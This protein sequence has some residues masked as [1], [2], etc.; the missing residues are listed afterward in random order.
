MPEMIGVTATISGISP[1]DYVRSGQIIADC[2]LEALRKIR[3]DAVFAIADLCVEAEALGCSLFYPEDN[4]PYVKKVILHN[5]GA[6]KKIGIPDP[7][8]DGR[9]PEILKA[10]RIL[11]QEVGGSV[12]VFAHVIGPITLAARIMDVEKMLYLIVDN[13]DKF[14]DVLNFCQQVSTTFAM[15]LVEE[16]A[17]G[18]IMFDS[19]ASPSVLPPKI[20]RE[21]E[22]NPVRTVFAKVKEIDPEVMTWYSVA[23]PV[24]TNKA[25]LKDVAADVSTVDYMVPID[26]AMKHSMTTVINGNI[27]P[28]LFQ[29]GSEKEIFQ[30]AITLLSATR[31]M[32]RFIL[33]SG[34]EIPLYSDIKK[35]SVLVKAVE[36]QAKIFEYVN[37]S[38]HKPHKIT[39]MPDG[40]K[41]RVSTGDNLLDVMFKAGIAITSYCENSGSCGRCLI[42][43]KKGKTTPPGKIEKLQLQSRDAHPNE[44]LACCIKIKEAMEIYIPYFSRTFQFQNAF[45]DK[46]YEKSIGK[47]LDIFGFKPNIEVK[48]LNLASLSGSSTLSYEKRIAKQ[49]NNYKIDPSIIGNFASLFLKRQKKQQDINAII[50]REKAEVIDFSCSNEIYG[51]AI[52]IGT[53]TISAFLHNLTTGELK[54][55]GSIENPQQQWG[56]DIITRTSKIMNDPTML[57]TQQ[58]NLI[59]AINKLISNFHRDHSVPN[60]QIYEIV[61]VGNSVM[62]YL[63]LGLSPE[64][65]AQS[66]FVSTVSQGVATSIENL[67]SQTKLAINPGCRIEILPGISSFVGADTMA[68]ILATG[69][70][71]KQKISLF[72]DIGTNSEIVLGNRGRLVCTSVPAGPAFEIS[73]LIHGNS[74]QNGIITSIDIDSAGSV[75]HE[76]TG[77]ATPYWMS[78]SSTIDAIAEFLRH[79]IIN[80]RGHFINTHQ[81]PQIKNNIFILVP[82][83]KTAHNSSIFIYN[84]DI[85]EIQKAKSAIMTGIT[86]LI[87]KMGIE[88]KDIRNI[89]ISGSF[90]INININ[91]AITI[92]MLPDFPWAKYQFIKNSAGIGARIALLSRN[93]RKTADDIASRVEHINLANHKDFFKYFIE[94]MLFPAQL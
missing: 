20:F 3:H 57:H 12:P 70:H 43:I 91:N 14:R 26:L 8:K 35:I 75:H 56:L 48:Q 92:G 2:Q 89:L 83:Q 6:I 41:I 67:H 40:K 36:E 9:L 32:E 63:F 74:Y 25:L 31:P 30:N 88:P 93:A 4:Y 10:V 7:H 38:A 59:E 51:L 13:P 82:K 77:N 85:E 34:C 78:G 90:G 61:V 28:M 68:G 49:L 66:P 1:R 45:S 24:H 69:I 60:N 21:F 22:L 18:I 42:Y 71:K 15:S 79:E 52:D 76:T 55:A 58:N 17:D 39:I 80:R 47:E 23:G 94:N 44:R 84:R 46:L 19:V 16:G 87:N 65:L 54:C 62:T 27:K 29:D 37:S 5:P 73:H 33:G 72:V 64:S 81:W 86:L 50:D 53:T 11:K